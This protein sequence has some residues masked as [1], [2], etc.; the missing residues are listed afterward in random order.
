[1]FERFHADARQA[2]VAARREAALMGQR[3]IGCSHLL[4]GILSEPDGP[5]ALALSAAGLE[6][7][8]LRA[9]IAAAIVPPAE[10]LD[11]DALASLGIDLDA[12]RRATEASFGQGAL[13]RA[14]TPRREFGSMRLTRPAK[15]SLECALRAAAKMHSGHISSGHLLLGLIDQEDNGAVATLTAAGV[16]TG[17]L[18]ADVMARLVAAA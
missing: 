2:V 13:E 16:D 18:R 6:L 17:A 5:G 15:K 1:M 12:V 7:A 8:G 4:L 10:P 11:A 9:R 14:A 3:E